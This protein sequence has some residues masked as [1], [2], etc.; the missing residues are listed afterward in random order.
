MMDINSNILG[1]YSPHRER[2]FFIIPNVI[3][4]FHINVVELSAF[5]SDEIAASLRRHRL[6]NFISLKQQVFNDSKLGEYANAMFIDKLERAHSLPKIES[7]SA[8]SI[9]IFLSRVYGV[10]FL[11]AIWANHRPNYINFVA[12]KQPIARLS[13]FLSKLG[14]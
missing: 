11:F 4:S 8:G 3:S 6:K 2:E 12:K 13:N 5:I 7:F 1:S 10:K 14:F 9:T